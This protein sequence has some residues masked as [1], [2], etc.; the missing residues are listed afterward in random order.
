MESILPSRPNVYTG[1]PL[2]RAASLRDDAGWIAAAAADAGSL[3]VPLWRGQV[4]VRG[5]TTAAVF[6]RGI[7]PRALAG[8][9][10]WAFLGRWRERAVFAAEL[11]EDTPPSGLAEDG[12]FIDLRAAV[13]TLP[14]DEAAVLAHA[15]A[16]LHWRARHRFCGFCGGGNRIPIERIHP[17]PTQ[18][19]MRAIPRHHSR[20][21][22]RDDL[23]L[24]IRVGGD[25]YFFA[26]GDQF[27]Q[28]SVP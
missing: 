25:D 26:I 8:E 17:H 22:L 18:P 28:V 6:L 10:A 7:D 21:I 23:A 12:R 11:G 14:A 4:L 24:A 16:M 1:N 20:D 15:R 19:E 2:D 13:A 3:V 27:D 5:E 9:R